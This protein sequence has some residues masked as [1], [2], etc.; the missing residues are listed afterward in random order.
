MG[1]KMGFNLLRHIREN[2]EYT[3]VWLFNIGLEKYWNGEV[4]TVKSSG[5]DVVV[6]H[7]E[8]MNLL[9]TR[10]QDILILR[11]MPDSYYLD[12]LKELKVEI[13]TI[14][15]PGIKDENKSIS[16]LVL[17]DNDLINKVK[18]LIA[19]RDKVIFVPYGVSTLEEDITDKLG[20]PRFGSG[21]DINKAINNKV[22]SREFALKHNFRVPGGIVCKGFE[23]LQA[24]AKEYLDKYGKI[25]I[26]EPCGAS[27][28]G[29]WVV[30]TPAKL[31]ST[32]LIIKRFFA[33][34]M[35]GDWL[36]EEWCT[37]QADLNYQVYVG[38]DGETQVFSIKEQIVNGTVYVGSVIPPSFS[39]EILARCNE[40][41]QIIGKELY[42]IGYRGI[43]GIDAMIL[44]NG[45]LVPIVEIN[46]RFTLSTYISFVEQRLNWED[47]KIFAFYKKIPLS[48]SENYESIVKKMQ[49]ANLWKKDDGSGIITYTSE[50]VNSFRVG[51]YGRLFVLTFAANEDEMMKYHDECVS[52]FA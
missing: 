38:S 14:V 33:E 21:N 43:L 37:K 45:E 41:G 52:L 2:D 27:G 50:T 36:V 17:E 23:E 1:N 8:E 18:E 49:N 16:E 32:L 51:E 34:H 39:E 35:D 47:K 19:D 6:N 7:M 42:S 25:I 40:C 15:C 10:S 22:F 12:T 48:E 4:F 28:K 30:E 11:D 9:L 13:P 20:I 3:V 29:L 24:N 31:K 26:K 44:D 46:G 5:D